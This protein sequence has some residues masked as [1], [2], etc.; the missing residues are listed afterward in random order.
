ME[1]ESSD[2]QWIQ[3]ALTAHEAALMRYAVRLM[4]GDV[5]QARDIV[6][7]AFLKLWQADRRNVEPRLLQWLYTVTRNRALDVLRKEGRM[8]ALNDERT[9]P[10][11]VSGSPEQPAE[12]SEQAHSALQ[13]LDDLPPRQQ[14]AIRL[15]FQSGLSYREIA[16]VMQITVNNVGVLIHTGIK[17][18]RERLSTDTSAAPGASRVAQ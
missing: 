10:A 7:D 12:R 14:E 15:K 6:Q 9:S 11:S 16:S 1:P 17:T 8:T 13:V 3:E 4:G 18:L 2:G 5:E